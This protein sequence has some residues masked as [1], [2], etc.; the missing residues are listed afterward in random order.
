MHVALARLSIT[1]VVRQWVDDLGATSTGKA[2]AK[3]LQEV[4][5][6]FEVV[7]GL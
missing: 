6:N 1:K 4:L 2:L 7:F 3:D 5:G